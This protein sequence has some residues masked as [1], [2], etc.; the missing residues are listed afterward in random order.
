M[1]ED[2]EQG[3]SA[4]RPNERTTWI[5]IGYHECVQHQQFVKSCE[6]HTLRYCVA[7]IAICNRNESIRAKKKEHTTLTTASELTR[8]ARLPT[9]IPAFWLGAIS[10]IVFHRSS[11]SENLDAPSASTI[12]KRSPL[13]YSIPCLTAPPFPTLCSNTTTRISLFGY[14]TP[15]FNAILDVSSE[16]PSSTT[17]IS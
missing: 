4:G 14:L 16:D 9:T 5:H 6:G 10:S 12:N 1:S 11:K 2:V 13:L 3:I 17:I 15:S 8:W 7:E